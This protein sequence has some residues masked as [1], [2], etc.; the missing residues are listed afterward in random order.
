MNEFLP[1]HPF[2]AR[3]DSSDTLA[4]HAEHL[5]DDQERD[6]KVARLQVDLE[7]LSGTVDEAR[8]ALALH[9]RYTDFTTK[10]RRKIDAFKFF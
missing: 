5:H 7:P 3:M 8:V 1:Q 9:Q 2:L 10:S 4:E 6:L